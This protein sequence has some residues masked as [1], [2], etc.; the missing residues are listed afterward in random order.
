M[1][2]RE[3]ST[4]PRA[5]RTRQALISATLDLLEQHSAHDLSVT[6]IVREAGVSRQVFYEHFTDRDGVVLA[7]GKAILEP[8]YR[9]FVE[10]FEP[11]TSYPEQVQKLFRRL[12]NHRGA[13]RTLMDSAAQGKLNR[14]AGE[15]LY[16][17]VRAELAEFGEHL[18][19]AG[20]DLDDDMLNETA[21]FLAA[22]T[23]EVFARGISE[24]I[25]PG[26]VAR[27]IEDVRRTIGAFALGEGL[28]ERQRLA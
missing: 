17:P 27:R 26:E 7:A 9:E 11:D 14:F 4:D 23:Q 19:D 2:R 16:A 22:G 18:K 20:I 25:A 13:V 3:A 15:I 6:T 1:T 8:A 5:V 28:H 12:A 24:D 21:R 10:T